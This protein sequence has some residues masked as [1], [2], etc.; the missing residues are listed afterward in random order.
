MI[1]VTVSRPAN[2]EKV[3]HV[4]WN[5]LEIPKDKWE[6]RSEDERAEEIFNILKT[7]KFVLLLDDIW[8]RLDLSKVGI[9]P[10]NHQDKLKM[11]F[12]TRSKHVCQD[13]EAAKSIEVNSLP[14]EDAF[15]LFQTNVRADTITSHPDI[16]KLAEMVAKKSDGLPL[17]LI[18]I[19]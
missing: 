6:G 14:W 19:G 12:T 4:V 7:K 10:L 1:L 17:A 9:P 5:K 2:L 3:Q 16:P 18:N 15:A 11:V 8:E 13:M